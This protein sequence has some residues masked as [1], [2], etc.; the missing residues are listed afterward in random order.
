MRR[1]WSPSL[2]CSLKLNTVELLRTVKTLNKT[3]EI[4]K[5]KNVNFIYLSTYFG[6]CWV[7]V[8]LCGLFSSCGTGGFFLGAM[9]AR[10]SH[11]S[12]FSCCGTPALGARASVVAAHGLS[13]CGAPAQL[14]CILW[15]LSGTGIKPAT[16]ALTGRFPTTGLP[17]AS[18]NFFFFN[19]R[20]LVVLVGRLESRK[21][22]CS[23]V[24]HS[25][26]LLLGL[27]V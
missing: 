9:R 27:V 11:C 14:T 4:F 8:A 26:L 22:L 3:E 5:K 10:A 1:D 17:R 15:N 16:S 12:G 23:S 21:G 7:F 13:S 25:C 20:R 18:K 6:L 24:S 2:Q 19:H